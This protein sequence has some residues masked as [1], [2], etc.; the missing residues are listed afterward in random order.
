MTAVPSGS[1]G[2]SPT[3]SAIEGWDTADLGTAASAWKQ[4]ATASEDAFEQHRQYIA[5]PGGTTWDGDA[6]DAALDRVTADV[7]V[8]RGHGEALRAAAAIAES[9]AIDIEAA[10][11]EVL[12]A[13]AQ[14]E[15]EGFRV[16]EDLSVID[17]RE[18]DVETM[19]ARQ[20]A[21]T[22]H[23]EDIRWYAE[24]L[25]Q[26]DALVGKR[27]QTKAS[28]LE[29][30]R[31]DGE[32][33]DQDGTV[34]LVDSKTPGDSAEERR[35]EPGADR[36]TA[37][38]QVGPFPVPKVVEDAA[39]QPEAMPEGKPPGISD[40]GGDLGDLLGAD[41][42]EGDEPEKP[43]DEK[44]AGLP[45]ALSQ[46]PPPPTP[47]A[48]EQQRARVEAARQ[49]LAAAQAKM[50]AAA[51]Q[52]YVQGAGAGTS[53]A[54]TDS[55]S[56]AVF[57]ARRELTEQTHILENL[58]HAA[59]AAGGPTGPVPA[60]P[61]NAEVQA[62]PPEPSGFAEGSRA[63]S[64]ASFGLIPDVAKDIDVFTNWEDHS[65]ADRIQAVLDAAGLVPL[66]GAKLAGE[67]IEHGLEV[68]GGATRHVD[69]VP[70]AHVDDVSTGG[71][72]PPPAD[73]PVEYNAPD[74]AASSVGADDLNVFYGAELDMAQTTHEIFT[75]TG[76]TELRQA[77]ANGVAAEVEINGYK[78]L[79]EPDIPGSGFSLASF[80]ERGFAIGPE[81]MSSESELARTVAHEVY[82]VNMTEIP[83]LGIDAT[84]ATSETQAAFD[85]AERFGESFL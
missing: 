46:L 4:A 53:R 5:A 75:S 2:A 49:D 45:P 69:D 38:G 9:G 10:K 24:R 41:G 12:A 47:A 73:A 65:T 29:E 26:A 61:E 37:P 20:I 57:D 31:F 48:V 18:V 21:A 67:G 76:M 35:A 14:A 51:G 64:D 63:L 13:I 1:G 16:G 70:T 85:F 77:A 78:V 15:N 8:V 42:A 83:E 84:R 17:T 81:A 60:L 39:K 43:G 3:R 36:A 79:Y 6:K 44:P 33:H 7:A 55:L 82:R 66:P 40:V 28:E 27:L 54:E 58:N 22:E 34:R 11:R 23:A 30:T 80:G 25:A 19:A 32:G 74:A 50:D 52:S 68:L 62:F 59:A 72:S 71:H 56:Q